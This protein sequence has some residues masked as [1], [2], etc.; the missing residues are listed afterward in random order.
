MSAFRRPPKLPPF[1]SLLP[2]LAI[3]V[4]VG[5]AVLGALVWFDI[6]GFG[7]VVAAARPRGVVVFMLLAVFAITWG[8]A[9]VGAAIMAADDDDPPEGGHPEAEPALVP[10]PV[11]AHRT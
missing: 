4:G 10:V 7:T 11:R 9:A 8:S 5:W 1:V 2:H 3:G 6:G